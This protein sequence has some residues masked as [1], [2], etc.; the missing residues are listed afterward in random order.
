MLPRTCEPSPSPKRPPDASWRSQ[1]AS[2][3]IIGLRG[4]ATSTLVATWRR[5]VAWSSDVGDADLWGSPGWAA[6]ATVV[7]VRRAESALFASVWGGPDHRAALE[8]SRR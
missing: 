2:A 4:K 7:D 6:S 8:R 3:A 5:E 1:A